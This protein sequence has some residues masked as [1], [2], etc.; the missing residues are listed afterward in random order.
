[1]VYIMGKNMGEK[2]E[3]NDIS[4]YCLKNNIGFDGKRMGR[5]M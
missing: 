2:R 3:T 1:M 5:Y 4:R